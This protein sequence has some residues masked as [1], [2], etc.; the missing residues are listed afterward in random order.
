MIVLL[1]H[2]SPLEKSRIESW[3]AERVPPLTVNVIEVNTMHANVPCD[4]VAVS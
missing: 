1:L 3:A 4:K 2:R